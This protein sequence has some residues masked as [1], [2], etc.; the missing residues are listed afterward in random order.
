MKP[1]GSMPHD[2]TGARTNVV[3]SKSSSR[4]E[5]S[6]I[7]VEGIVPELQRLAS[8]DRVSQEAIKGIIAA[9]T[10]MAQQIEATTV[11]LAAL[12]TLSFGA[13]LRWAFT[14]TPKKAA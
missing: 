5:L 2:T 8:N 10:A 9:H 11:R 3:I 4:R 7:V 12:E 1:N 14:F 13:R 6:R